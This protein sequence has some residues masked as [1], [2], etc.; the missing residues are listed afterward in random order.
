M[1]EKIEPVCAV[2]GC[3]KRQGKRDTI[4]PMHRARFRATGNYDGVR[5]KTCAH[6]GKEWEHKPT[7][8]RPVKY[9]SHQ[10]SQDAAVKKRPKP[11]AKH[12][13]EYRL[14]SRYGITRADYE[15]MYEEQTG[16]CRICGEDPERLYIDHCHATGAVRG[17]L[18]WHCNSGLGHF[19]DDP[20]RLRMAIQYLSND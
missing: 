20:D 15:R 12:S 4:C 19:R 6:C 16:R 2:E 18:C 17:L 10:C 7:R 14:K 8:G 11:K 13:E 3:S 5:T 9:C 1:P